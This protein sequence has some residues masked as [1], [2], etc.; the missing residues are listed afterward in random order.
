MSNVPLT[1]NDNLEKGYYWIKIG[2]EKTIGYY[3][4]SIDKMYNGSLISAMPWQ[5]I[6]SDE[7]Y[8]NNELEV[9]K[10]VKP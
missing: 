8:R 1:N 7:L 4:G 10:E 6:G 5:I 3:D 2:D 9:I